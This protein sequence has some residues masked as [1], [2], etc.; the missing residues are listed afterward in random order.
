MADTQVEIKK[1]PPAPAPS[2][3]PDMWRSFQRE[4]DRL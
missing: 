1:A 2:A 3:P 4:M